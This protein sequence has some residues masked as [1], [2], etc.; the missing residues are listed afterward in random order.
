MYWCTGA[1]ISSPHD[2]EVLRCIEESEEPWSDA[3]WDAGLADRSP[4]K[5]DPLVEVTSSY[6]E[7]LKDL[8]FHRYRQTEVFYHCYILYLLGIN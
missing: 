7:E 2:K 8:C 5:T 4:L 3:C 6:M 1:Q